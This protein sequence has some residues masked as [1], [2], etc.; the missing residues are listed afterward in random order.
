M[1]DVLEPLPRKKEI[2]DCYYAEQFAGTLAATT[3]LRYS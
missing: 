3:P 2:M 1:N